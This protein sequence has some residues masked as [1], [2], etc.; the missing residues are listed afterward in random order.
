MRFDIDELPV[1]FPF[2]MVYKEQLE[3]MREIKRAL[4]MQV[5]HNH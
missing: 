5:F 4:D 1:Y 3:Y 2:E